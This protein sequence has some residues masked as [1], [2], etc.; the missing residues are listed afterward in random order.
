MVIRTCVFETGPLQ[1]TPKKYAVNWK[2]ADKPY[3]LLG[4]INRFSACRRVGSIPARDG[5]AAQTFPQG[6]SLS[7]GESVP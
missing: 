4:D 2:L 5:L 3:R 7:G 6:G 1:G